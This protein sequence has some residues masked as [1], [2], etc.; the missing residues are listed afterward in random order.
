MPDEEMNNI[1]NMKK[2]KH[3]LTTKNMFDIN[4]LLVILFTCITFYSCSKNSSAP[5]I[6]QEGLITYI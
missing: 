5:K 4:K 2:M 6:S 3:P 1:L